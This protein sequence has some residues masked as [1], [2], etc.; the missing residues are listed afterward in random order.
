MHARQVRKKV[1][2]TLSVALQK[3]ADLKDARPFD[4]NRTLS[5]ELCCFDHSTVKCFTKLFDE[6][7]TGSIRRLRTFILLLDGSFRCSCSCRFRGR[8]LVACRLLCCGCSRFRFSNLRCL[9]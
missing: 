8:G 3:I 5:Y 9:L 6:R 1:E 7:M 2:A 4:A